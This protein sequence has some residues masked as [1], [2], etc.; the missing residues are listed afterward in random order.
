MIFE[1]GGKK[2]NPLEKEAPNLSP[3]IL[4]RDVSHLGFPACQIIIP[5]MSNI[6]PI[7]PLWSR[8]ISTS[9]KIIKNTPRFPKLTAQDEEL[10]LR[11]IRFKENSAIE[12]QLDAIF[13]LPVRGK[14]INSDF[15]GGFLAFKQEKFQLAIHFFNKLY[16]METNESEKTILLARIEYLRYRLSGHTHEEASKLIR[17]FFLDSVAAQVKAYTING[18]MQEKIYNVEMLADKV[19]T[20]LKNPQN[21]LPRTLPNPNEQNIPYETPYIYLAPD[22]RGNIDEKISMEMA[23]VSN[24]ADDLSLFAKSEIGNSSAYIGS[25]NGYMICAYS[26]LDDNE[27]MVFSPEE[28]QK[29]IQATNSIFTA[30]IEKFSAETRPLFGNLQDW[31]YRL[32]IFLLIFMLISEIWLAKRFSSPIKNLSD[33]VKEITGGNLD[34]KFDIH[35]SDEIEQL[36]NGFNTMITEVNCSPPKEA[37]ASWII[38]VALS[39][40]FPLTQ[41][42]LPV[43]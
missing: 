42:L 13:A 11:M 16:Q 8:A 32:K 17:R 15:V 31:T 33:G 19:S 3:A 20:I 43:V 41:A 14:R 6:Y 34:K 30:Q 24:I 27:N 35:T 39:V 29:P 2:F 25:K 23:L 26:K 21:Y 37:G 36:A 38:E 4:L 1:D 10:I 18:V 22:L 12:N 9:L 40:L 5:K 7:V 28:V